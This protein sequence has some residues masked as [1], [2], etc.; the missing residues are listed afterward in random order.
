MIPFAFL[1]AATVCVC[2]H[3]GIMLMMS[4][5]AALH[6]P[7]PPAAPAELPR[8]AIIVAARDEENDL[9]R[10]LEA[11]LAQNYPAGRLDIYV[12]DDHS[13]DGT[14]NVIRQ[15]QNRSSEGAG[16]AIHYVTVPDAAGHLQ[17][18]ANALHAAIG[19]SDHEILLV[20]DADCAPPPD[21]ARNHAAYFADPKVGMVC[22][23]AYVEHHTLLDAVQ[24]LD[25]S[26]LLTSA[27][28]LTETGRPTTAMGNNMAFRRTAYEAVG[29]YPAL[30]FSVTEDYVLFQ[31][32]AR[33]TNFRVRFPLDPG[34]HTI[35]L[36]LKRLVD[37]YRQR[38]RWARGGLR[39]PA[40]L[41]AL[42]LIAHLAHLLPAIALFV[43]PFWALSL[44]VLKMFG[45]F[46]LLWVALGIS[47]RRKMLRAF[48]LFEAY[49]FAYMISLPLALAVSRRINWKNRRL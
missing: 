42:Y 3:A 2:L 34:L 1:L 21:W 43:A 44:I 4:A 38:R 35:T 29:G 23:Q 7:A 45:D 15:F 40:W 47:Q 49:L 30:P 22:G 8:V 31:T 19:T 27:S 32:V 20:T 36:P 46:S 17:G 9:P 24:A 33:Q 6:R 26:Y 5:V 10:C 11:L 41:Y 18:K 16:A 48:P 39:A 25:W 37:V 12:A 14:A 28:I 13:T